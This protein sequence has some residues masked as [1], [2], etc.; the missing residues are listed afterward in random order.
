MRENGKT[1]RLGDMLRGMAS[2][3]NWQG[4]LLQHGV[5]LR[6]EQLVGPE[7]ARVARPE[8]IRDGTL[9][10]RV[11]DQ[12]WVQQLQY[13]QTTM[14]FAINELLSSEQRIGALRFRLDTGL[15]REIEGERREE[16]R[17]VEEAQS[18]PKRDPPDPAREAEF[19]RM[20]SG[21]SDPEARDNLLRIW[22][23]SQ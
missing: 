12:V 1:D 4:A 23:K 20:I 7:I 13:E 15:A 5:F 8:V 21:L 14:L 17:A 22:R 3:K 18:P 2:G 19:R 11:V 9:W 10:V 16:R 6:W